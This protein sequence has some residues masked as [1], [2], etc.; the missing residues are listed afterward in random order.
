MK[1]GRKEERKVKGEEIEGGR[2]GE[3]AELVT[4]KTRQ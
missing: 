2:K 3:R 1:E 4:I